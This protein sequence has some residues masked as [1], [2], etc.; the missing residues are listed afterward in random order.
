MDS[1]RVILGPI[2]TEKAERLKTSGER[3]VYTMRIAPDA[4]KIDVKNTL[5]ELYDAQVES[6][7]VIKTRAKTRMLGNG[8]LMEKRHAGKKVLVTLAPKSKALDL[9][10]FRTNS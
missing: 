9:S 2:V 3:H 5:R 1:S 7:R 4:T 10:A 6:V 8:K